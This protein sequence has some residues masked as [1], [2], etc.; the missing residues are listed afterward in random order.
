MSMRFSSNSGSIEAT[1]VIDV[2]LT[3]SALLFYATIRR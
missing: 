2:T 1:T 3:P